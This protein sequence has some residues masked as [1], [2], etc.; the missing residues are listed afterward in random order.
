MTLATWISTIT[1]GRVQITNPSNVYLTC[2]IGA[3]MHNFHPSILG[4]KS[5][6]FIDVANLK[7]DV[8]KTKIRHL[9]FPLL[10]V[11]TTLAYRSDRL[12]S[13]LVH[14]QLPRSSNY[15]KGLLCKLLLFVSR[16]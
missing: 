9:R 7:C 12:I 11:H 16:A 8:G 1:N 14:L 15:L 5:D 13:P 3:A 2:R 4:I 6:A 10:S